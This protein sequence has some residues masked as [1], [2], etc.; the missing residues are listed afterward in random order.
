MG[1]ELN[2]RQKYNCIIEEID[3]MQKEELNNR[4]K[5]HGNLEPWLL[6]FVERFCQLANKKNLSKKD[7]FDKCQNPEFQLPQL[8]HQQIFS[9]STLSTITNPESENIRLPS[10]N[11]LITLSKFF[12]VSI[13]YLVGL[14]EF[15]NHIDDSQIRNSGLTPKIIEVSNLY[16]RILEQNKYLPVFPTETSSDSAEYYPCPDDNG[17]FPEYCY[18]NNVYS[19]EQIFEKMDKIIEEFPDFFSVTPKGEICEKKK[20]FNNI[21]PNKHIFETLEL[22][23][24]YNNGAL[25]N[26]LADYLFSS[27]EVKYPYSPA[28]DEAPKSDALLLLNIFIQLTTL[29]ESKRATT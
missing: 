26:G 28:P 8:K 6:T 7:I 4:I 19:K 23:L 16:S 11:N 20:E 13:D 21:K 2:K 5:N 29:R 27:A 9:P 14:S 22:I 24:T 1:T 25:I 18:G 12:D 10:I 17:F 15:K 3:P